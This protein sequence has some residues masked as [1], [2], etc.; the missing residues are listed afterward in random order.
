ME[1]ERGLAH[2]YYKR[3][4]EELAGLAGRGLSLAG[5][6]FAPVLLLKGELNPAER[7]GGKLLA[8]PDGTALSAAFDRLGYPSDGWAA[9]S[10]CAHAADGS[11]EPAAPRLLAEAVEVLDPELA[12][13]LDE[14]AARALQA[15]WD[16]PGPFEPGRV[17]RVRGRRVLALGGFEA[18]LADPRAKQV[19]WA[20]LKRVPP[21]GAPL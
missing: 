16:L 21:L 7:A 11:W 10:V 1:Q 14:T 2:L 20:R 13:A 6:A 9:C 15:A 8:G 18:A 4:C 17:H 12:V 5:H 3:T 19:M